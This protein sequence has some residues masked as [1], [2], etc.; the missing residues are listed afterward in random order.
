[1]NIPE[2]EHQNG[3]NIL[4]RI[5]AF[6]SVLNVLNLKCSD[7]LQLKNVDKIVQRSVVRE[8]SFV[9]FSFRPPPCCVRIKII[10]PKIFWRA[11]SFY[12]WFAMGSQVWCQLKTVARKSSTGITFVQRG[13]TS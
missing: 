12:L 8:P 1:L 3:N 11:F 7:R 10:R 9:R 13:L 6:Q 2:S 5:N 4:Q